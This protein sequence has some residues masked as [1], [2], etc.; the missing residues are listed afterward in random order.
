MWA[1]QGEQHTRVTGIGVILRAVDLNSF[2][3][4]LGD[5]TATRM[6]ASLGRGVDLVAAIPR[7]NSDM[8]LVLLAQPRAVASTQSLKLVVVIARDFPVAAPHKLFHSRLKVSLLQASWCRAALSQ[9][10]TGN[11]P[12]GVR[13]LFKR[14]PRRSRLPFLVLSL[15]AVLSASTIRLR[16]A[17]RELGQFSREHQVGAAIGPAVLLLF[18]VP[19]E[20]SSLQL[21]LKH[22]PPLGGK[23]LLRLRSLPAS[24]E[25]VLLRHEESLFGPRPQPVS[26]LGECLH[27]VEPN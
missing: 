3:L 22:Q 10:P 1:T 14:C 15:V 24:P 21:F 6:L 23:V 5:K 25:Q 9:S 2:L 16:L 13:E 7:I 18:R 12:G 27:V 11:R 17:R 20:A 26:L 8:P 4:Q 19:E